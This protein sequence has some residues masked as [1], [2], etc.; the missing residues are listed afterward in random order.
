MEILIKII[1]SFYDTYNSSIYGIWDLLDIYTR[2]RYLLKTK[3]GFIALFFQE[4]SGFIALNV[5]KS[6]L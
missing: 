5:W 3:N 1:L 6:L 4:V 2:I